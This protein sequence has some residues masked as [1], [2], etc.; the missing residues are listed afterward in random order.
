MGKF[1][2]ISPV[3]CVSVVCVSACVSYTHFF[4]VVAGFFAMYAIRTRGQE[5]KLEKTV[6]T[7]SAH[8][9][10]ANAA[11]PPSK[12]HRIGRCSTHFP[13]P[14]RLRLPLKPKASR[15]GPHLHHLGVSVCLCVCAC[16]CV[17]VCMCMCLCVCVAHTCVA[18]RH[19]MYA[20]R[21]RAVCT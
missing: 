12:H 14:L 21:T 1:L 18:G 15:V 2:T 3:V 11:L 20:I 8:N 13:L 9:E 17:S 6:F 5:A 16:V 4:F 7:W 19:A 10:L